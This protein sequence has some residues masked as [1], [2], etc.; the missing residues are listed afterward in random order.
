MQDAHSIEA[1][2]KR[3]SDENEFDDDVRDE[4]LNYFVDKIY[5][6]D[7]RIIVTGPYFDGIA[8]QISFDELTDESIEFEPFAVGSRSA[9]SFFSFS[10]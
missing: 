1:Y 8:E 7:D 3:Y 10:S 6:Y 5:V 4:V 2:F 9:V